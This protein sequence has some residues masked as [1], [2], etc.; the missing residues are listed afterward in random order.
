MLIAIIVGALVPVATARA[1]GDPGSDVLVNQNLFAPADLGLSIAQQVQLGY[2]LGSAAQHGAAVRVAII[3]SRFDLGAVT[4][5][6]LKPQSYARFLGI[7]L[8]LAY[9]QR[10]LVVMPD[11]FGLMW[12]GHSTAAADRALARI[13]IKPGGRGLF[14]ATE[15]AVRVLVSTGRAGPGSARR[16]TAAGAS[17]APA[18]TA[19]PAAAPGQGADNR[20]ALVTA[21]LAIIAAAIL[22]LQLWRRSRADGLARR[23]VIAAPL[24]RRPSA[25][26]QRWALP[27][28][29]VGLAAVV[30]AIP[31]V[32]FNARGGP[33]VSQEAPFSPFLDPGTPLHGAAP[34]FTLGDQFG[35]TVSLRAFRGKV[36]LLAF[37]DTECTTV[38]PL[39]TQAMLDAKA[40]LGSAGAQ[41]QLLGI[42]ANPR[43]TSLEDVW[44]YSQLHGMLHAWHFLTGSLPQL[45]RVWKAYAIYAAIEHGEV[46]H[47][48]ALFV[49]SPRGEEAKVY[50]TQMSYS[51]VGQLGK[52]LAEEASSL[53]PGHPPV[54]STFSYA[55][56]AP[57]TPTTQ[58]DLPRSGG[59]SVRLGPGHGARLLL[60]FA[61]WDREITS[62]A[63]HLT[64]LDSYA[65]AAA[66][67]GLPSLAAVDEG[68]VEPSSSALSSFLAELR[69][70]LSY[71]V[72][73]DQRGRFADGYE[74]QGAPWYVLVSSS[75]Q[76]VWYWQVST[77]GW[78]SRV[79][80][81]RRVRTAL[82]QA[83]VIAGSAAEISKELA[84]SPA[85]LTALHA[86]A[87]RL[88]G[89]EPALMARIRALRGYPIVVNAW[90]S[91]CTPCRAEFRLFAAA[92][93]RYGRQVAFLGADTDDSRGDAQAFLEQHP[94]SYPSYTATTADLGSLAVTEGLPT[95]IFIAP[96]GR[97]VYVHIGQYDAQGALDADI[98]AHVSGA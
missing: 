62:L 29:A 23:P 44:S 9:T 55:P 73:V 43:S 27:V 31:F 24:D 69:H 4:A 77:G 21:M 26:T 79:A 92:S 18:G 6:W 78:L 51:A 65:S 68:S 85:P 86:Q 64:A 74:V 38:C 59:G 19:A 66:S 88:L 36:V 93:A 58:A 25:G 41:V 7:E 39:T 46:T 76:I 56:I 67:S 45:E 97:V 20:V 22:G 1:D 10:L 42:D 40:M 32:W 84:G 12:P 94:V 15:A 8:S 53:L 83:S 52:L 63:G 75:G 35:Q 47:T 81:A 3:A 13:P 17:A 50:L 87:D 34:D 30:V 28:L 49:I 80:L 2:Q 82:A 90:A 61:T 71:P 16:T 48:P 11:G 33:A 91:W 57:I 60:F 89:A 14:D 70:P 54:H 37:N 95:T 5:L 96:G 98:A 72:V